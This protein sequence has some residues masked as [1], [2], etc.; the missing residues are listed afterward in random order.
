VIDENG[1][2]FWKSEIPALCPFWKQ[3][4]KTLF[5]DIMKGNS[6][7]G[8]EKA[9]LNCYNKRDHSP[10]ERKGQRPEGESRADS[11]KRGGKNG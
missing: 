11:R 8:Q 10:A 1:Q 6:S 7:V 2:D 5:P 9:R 4:K 3:W